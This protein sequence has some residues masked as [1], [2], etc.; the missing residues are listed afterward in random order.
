MVKNFGERDRAMGVK[1]G[2][3]LVE[4]NVWDAYL[5]MKF[6]LKAIMESWLLKE[7]EGLSRGSTCEMGMLI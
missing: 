4:F 6:F 5:P 2:C 7:E 1:I 3:F